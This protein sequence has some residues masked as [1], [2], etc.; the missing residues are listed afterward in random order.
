MTTD[1]CLREGAV[2]QKLMNAIKSS[3]LLLLS[4]RGTFNKAMSI[5]DIRMIGIFLMLSE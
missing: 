2:L 5:K 3:V 1:F 4:E